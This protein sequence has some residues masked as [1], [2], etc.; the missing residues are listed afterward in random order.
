MSDSKVL[1]SVAKRR[2]PAAGMGRKKGVPNKTTTAAREAFQ[3][4]FDKI[5]GPEALAAWATKEPT[6]FYK[7]FAR[8]IPVDVNAKGDMS[9][10]IIVRWAGKS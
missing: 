7:L 9:G 6:E 2:P 10:E 3:M 1:A 5:G 4:A 8:L